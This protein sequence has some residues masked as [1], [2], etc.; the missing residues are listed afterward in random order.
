MSAKL[1]SNSRRKKQSFNYKGVTYKPE[2]AETISK[3]N[4]ADMFWRLNNLYYIVNEDGEVVKFKLRPAQEQFLRNMWYRNVILKSRQHGFST[5]IDV[6]ILD[7]CLFV[8]NT[9]AVIIAHKKDSAAEIMETKV[10]FPYVNLHPQIR[11]MITLVESNKTALKFSNGSSIHVLTS[12]R[13]GTCQLLH[14]SE[15]GYI[16]KHRPDIAEEIVLGSFPTVHNNGFIFVE[17]TADGKDGEFYKLTNKA[18]NDKKM[19]RKLTSLG[20]KGHFYA[21]FDKPENRLTDKDVVNV[22]IPNRLIAYFAE[23]KKNDDIELDI[24]QMS[25][26]A[27]QESLL[28]DKMLQEHPS[29]PK[30]AFDASGEGHYFQKQME[31]MRAEGRIKLVPHVSGRLVHSFWDLGLNDEMAIWLMQRIGNKWQAIGYLEDTDFGMD[32]YIDMIRDHAMKEKWSLGEWWGPHDIKR[33]GAFDALSPWDQA[34]DYGVTFKVVPKV[35]DKAVAITSARRAMSLLEIDEQN[36]EEGIARL[37]N[38]RKEWDAIRGAWKDKPRHDR[39]SNGADALMTW[40]LSLDKENLDSS[41]GVAR[42]DP[43]KMINST[44]PIGQETPSPKAGAPRRRGRNSMGAY[45]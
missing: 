2:E 24:N 39:N 40:S 31:Q 27:V 28:G 13:S 45:T 41:L 8:P 14:V 35:S 26:Y 11:D 1:Y 38:Y 20:F 3:A 17:S 22:T 10:E 6:F 33:R 16:S 12:G 42:T 29:T 7:Q 19:G 15:L 34:K 4:M 30:E 18:M 43:R 9:R 32:H 25:W 21:W 36:C 5:A 37:D 23:L 44:N